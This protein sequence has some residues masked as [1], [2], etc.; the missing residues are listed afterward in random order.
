[1]PTTTANMR[2]EA[3]NFFITGDPSFLG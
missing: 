3:S 1:M 2:I